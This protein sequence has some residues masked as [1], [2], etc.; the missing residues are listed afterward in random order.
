MR[1][2]FRLEQRMVSTV[3]CVAVRY[4]NS[5]PDEIVVVYDSEYTV[6]RNPSEFNL[7]PHH[8][9]VAVD[10]DTFKFLKNQTSKSI[11]ILGK[12]SLRFPCWVCGG[13]N[14]LI[15][16][17]FLG[18]LRH[19]RKKGVTFKHGS[20]TPLNLKSPRTD[21]LFI[22]LEFDEEDNP[23]NGCVVADNGYLDGN[24][25]FWLPIIFES[26]YVL[27][28]IGSKTAEWLRKEVSFPILE[29]RNVDLTYPCGE[30][31]KRTCTLVKTY[32]VWRAEIVRTRF[33]KHNKT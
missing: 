27:T 25:D 18:W 28:A 9:L 23:V 10:M 5:I 7:N 3:A 4:A 1:E 14:C 8:D 17:A 19:I 24:P 21:R 11:K 15:T 22:A 32:Y 2:N 20:Q 6:F 30:C 13:E 16:I 33:I 26:K 29:E 31:K 12:N